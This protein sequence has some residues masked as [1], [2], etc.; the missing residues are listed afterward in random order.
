MMRTFSPILAALIAA[1]ASPSGEP[2]AEAPPRAISIDSGMC[3]GACPVF[4]VTASAD[5]VG[6]FEGRSATAVTGERR[7]P[8]TSA[9]YGALVAN[10]AALRP[11]RGSAN[12]DIGGD[13]RSQRTD[14][15]TFVV[16]W[17][18]DSGAQELRF[19]TGC[20]MGRNRDFIA[21]LARVAE[22]L[23]I[24]NFISDRR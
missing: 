15:P 18:T 7:F 22:I 11:A 19:N 6:I 2:S 23:P 9:Q 16:T 1:C 24:R 10:L 14:H 4:R 5:G 13:C 17:R 12:H 21:R 20:E 3:Y 8:V